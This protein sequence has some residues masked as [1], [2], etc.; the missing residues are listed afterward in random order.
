[1]FEEIFIFDEGRPPCDPSEVKE[2]G[3]ISCRFLYGLIDGLFKPVIF[4]LRF[5]L[6]D[7]WLLRTGVRGVFRF[8]DR[9]LF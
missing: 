8:A 1:V 5:V 2:V 3:G 9:F 4:V 6:E 7:D